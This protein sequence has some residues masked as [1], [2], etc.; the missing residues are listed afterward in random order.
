MGRRIFFILA[1][2][3]YVHEMRHPLRPH[4][5]THSMNIY[6]FHL[7]SIGVRNVLPCV[8]YWLIILRKMIYQASLTKIIRRHTSKCR[9]HGQLILLRALLFHHIG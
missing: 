6:G 7:D 9:F 1:Q 3:N 8:Y 5:N 4:T 2:A